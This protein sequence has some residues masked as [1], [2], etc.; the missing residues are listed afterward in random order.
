MTRIGIL[1]IL[2]AMSGCAGLQGGGALSGR[3][4]LQRCEDLKGFTVAA[5]EI[6]LPT[7]GAVVAGDAPWGGDGGHPDH[8]VTTGTRT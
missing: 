4:P 7:R 6:G 2:L 3:L 1:V 5:A 8:K